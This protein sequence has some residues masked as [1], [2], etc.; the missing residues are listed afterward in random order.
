MR[1][2]WILAV[3]AVSFSIGAVTIWTAALMPQFFPIWSGSRN[4]LEIVR[5]HATLWRVN[6]ALFTTS[7]VAVLIG[8][9]LVFTSE[10]GPLAIPSLL[11][12][13]VATALWVAN[14]AM[15]MSAVVDVATDRTSASQGWLAFAESWTSALWLIASALVLLAFAGLGLT[16]LTSAVLG[17]WIGWV[18]IA[19]AVLSLG[20]LVLLRDVP[21]VVAYLPVLPLAIATGIAAVTT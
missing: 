8:C 20:F 1:E 15:R 3:A 10:T 2:R 5:R 13:T 6:A 4:Q 7:A 17:A 9:A 12:L 16:T 19:S 14:N 11:V 18:M 21:P